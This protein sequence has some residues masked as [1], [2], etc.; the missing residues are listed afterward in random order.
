MNLLLFNGKS[1]GDA[2]VKSHINGHTDGSEFETALLE[3]VS[4]PSKQF[5]GTLNVDGMT[6]G[7]VA[8]TFTVWK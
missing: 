2:R 5:I 1:E 6:H 7:S 8:C 4:L 3:S